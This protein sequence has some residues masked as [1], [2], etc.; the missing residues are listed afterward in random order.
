MTINLTL[1]RQQ[2]KITGFKQELQFKNN[3]LN[4]LKVQV[5]NNNVQLNQKQQKILRNHAIGIKTD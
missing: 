1:T 5:E 4:E 3:Q 2:S